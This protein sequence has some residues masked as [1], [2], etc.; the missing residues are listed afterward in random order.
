MKLVPLTQNR[1]AQVDDEDYKWLMLWKWHYHFTGYARKHDDNDNHKIIDM[2]RF[3]NNTPEGMS[4]DHVDGNRLNNQ[5]I[6]LR[7]CTHAQNIMNSRKMKKGSSVYKGVHWSTRSNCWYARI[8]FN[9]KLIHLGVFKNEKKA[10][11][12]YNNKAKELFGEFA[13]LNDI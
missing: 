4:T 12:A 9:Y 6:N 3:I 11:L 10:G 1:S 8:V 13:R 7:T 5:K 2:H